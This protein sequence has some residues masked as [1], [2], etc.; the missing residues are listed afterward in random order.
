MPVIKLGFV[1]SRR[2]TSFQRQAK[3]VEVNFFIRKPVF[4]RW[5]D[6]VLGKI[7]VRLICL[8]LGPY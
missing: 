4:S 7:V 5:S 2:A 3:V 1:L 6:Q 8:F